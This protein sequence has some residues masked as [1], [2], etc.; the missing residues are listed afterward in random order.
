MENYSHKWLGLFG[1]SILAFTAYLD[2]TIVNTALP[3]IQ[4]AFDID[5]LQL[6]WVSNIFSIIVSMTMIAS[7]KFGDLWGRKRLFYLGVGVFAIAAMGAGM[8]PNIDL[9]I[10]F[11]G[12]QAVGA[13]ILFICSTALISQTFPSEFRYKAIGI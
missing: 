13:S 10:F 6:Q 8:S 1:I 5:I 4:K 9:L 3:F 2:F 12:L 11:R 7:G